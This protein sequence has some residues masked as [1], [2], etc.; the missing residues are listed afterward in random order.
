MHLR[1]A[2]LRV[3]LLGSDCRSVPPRL[4]RVGCRPAGRGRADSE[5][6]LTMIDFMIGPGVRM[7]QTSEAAW[8]ACRSE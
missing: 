4:L 1:L 3:R 8:T 5:A 6:Y 7:T 2:S